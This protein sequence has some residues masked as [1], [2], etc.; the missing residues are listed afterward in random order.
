MITFCWLF[1]P[2]LEKFITFSDY[3]FDFIIIP[4]IGWLLTR[5]DRSGANLSTHSL[6]DLTMDSTWDS[7]DVFSSICF[8]FWSNKKINF[9]ALCPF[10]LFVFLVLVGFDTVFLSKVCSLVK[11]S[12]TVKWSLMVVERV[13]VRTTFWVITWSMQ[14][15][16]VGVTL[17]G[18]LFCISKSYAS[19]RATYFFLSRS[20]FNV[21]MLKSPKS[22]VSPGKTFRKYNKVSR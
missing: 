22:N 1:N 16:E 6:T 14:L 8:N 2:N 20:S 17:V 4:L 5:T 19:K 11:C 7:T 10:R 12:K 13:W 15:L 21:T 9:N 3:I 18:N